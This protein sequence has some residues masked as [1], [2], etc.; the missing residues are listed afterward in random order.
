VEGLRA[1]SYPLQELYY[2]GPSTSKMSGLW[3]LS[4]RLEELESGT[5]RAD[6]V[7]DDYYA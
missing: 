6:E 4:N 5:I 1:P 7:F 3:V 2:S